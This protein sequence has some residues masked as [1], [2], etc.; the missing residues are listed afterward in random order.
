MNT[1]ANTTTIE[2]RSARLIRR[3]AAGAMLGAAPALIALGTATAGHADT[4]AHNPGPSVSAPSHPAFPGQTTHAD[5]PGT[6][7][8]HHHQKNNAN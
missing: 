1:T 6:P 5:Q 4:V 2:S 7:G 8:H 3:C